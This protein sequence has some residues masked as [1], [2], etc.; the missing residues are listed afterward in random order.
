MPRSPWSILQFPQIC[1]VQGSSLVYQGSL[2]RVM[3]PKAPMS[4]LTESGVATGLLLGE[5]GW[6]GGSESRAPLAQGES[7]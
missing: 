2:V 3:P 6:E 5:R 1:D 4:I 7:C